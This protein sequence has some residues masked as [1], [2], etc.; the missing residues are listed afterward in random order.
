MQFCCACAEVTGHKSCASDAWGNAL[1]V[2]SL[3]RLTTRRQLASLFAFQLFGYLLLVLIFESRNCRIVELGIP[4]QQVVYLGDANDLWLFKQ[5][6]AISMAEC[7]VPP[8]PTPQPCILH[9]APRMTICF[10]HV[11]H[12]LL[13]ALTFASPDLA[14][15]FPNNTA[16]LVTQVMPVNLVSAYELAFFFPR[17][18]RAC[19]FIF[20]NSDSGR[21]SGS[22]PVE[23]APET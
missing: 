5:P 11:V 15:M 20:F 7:R 6:R 16:L 19:S 1:A 8:C 2:M 12:T 17:W 18:P 13:R 22:S 4:Q 23:A 14:Y 9:P 21:P 10:V 3:H